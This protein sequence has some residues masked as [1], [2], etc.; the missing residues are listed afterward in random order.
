M[1]RN[2]KLV[3]DINFSNGSVI[4]NEKNKIETNNFLNY[5]R[6]SSGVI[7]LSPEK[8]EEIEIRIIM[9]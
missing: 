3:H 7:R 6:E 8:S 9:S 5:S 2:N 4:V 1:W